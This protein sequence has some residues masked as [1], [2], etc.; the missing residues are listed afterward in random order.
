MELQDEFPL[1]DQQPRETLDCIRRI[2]IYV[3]AAVPSL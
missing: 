2:Y 1:A 3:T